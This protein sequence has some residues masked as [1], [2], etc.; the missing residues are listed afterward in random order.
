MLPDKVLCT[1]QIYDRDFC[2]VKYWLQQD[3]EMLYWVA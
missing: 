2:K 1:G 3:A